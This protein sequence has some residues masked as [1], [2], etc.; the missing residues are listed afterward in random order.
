MRR[1]AKKFTLSSLLFILLVSCAK[2][3][4]YHDLNE[5]EANEIII[6]LQQNGIVASKKKEI[7]Q[8]EVFWVVVMSRSDLAQAREIVKSAG[9]PRIKELGLAGVYKEKGLIPTPDEQKARFLLALKG[10]IINSLEKLPEVIDAD[11]ILNVPT[12]RE[13]GEGVKKR[14]TASVIVKTKPATKESSSIHEGKMQEFVAG[15][16]EGLAPRDV[17]VIISYVTQGGY[18]LRPG[19][20]VTLPGRTGQPSSMSSTVTGLAQLAGLKLDA[21][22]KEK[23]KMYLIVV[24]LV[25]LLLSTALIFT[26]IQT[27][28]FRQE[29]KAMKP[30][31]PA[32]EGQVMEGGRPRLPGA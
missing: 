18:P 4:L 25:L 5:E 11:V 21:S 8:N 30:Q 28:R 20:T 12:E 27:N 22:S 24:V 31:A 26:L 6:V 14:P 2:E 7:R 9:L 10:E 1:N 32:I 17:S 15:A 29:L 23:L 16:V 19:E 13:L 3:G